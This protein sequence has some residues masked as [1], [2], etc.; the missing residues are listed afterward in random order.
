MTTAASIRSSAIAPR[1]IHPSNTAVR[2]FASDESCLFAFDP[3]TI[4]RI[5]AIRA[6]IIM[7]GMNNPKIRSTRPAIPKVRAVDPF[8]LCVF[9]LD[10][11]FKTS[12]PIFSFNVNFLPI[13]F[14]R[15][16]VLS[17]ISFCRSSDV[18]RIAVFE[19]EAMTVAGKDD[20]N[21]KKMQTIKKE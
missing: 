5:D 17:D 7:Y 9:L 4:A 20:G 19:G 3:K 11:Y 12:S 2:A 10:V 15:S 14:C 18:D 16:L 13:N 8:L 6:P 1:V 21:I